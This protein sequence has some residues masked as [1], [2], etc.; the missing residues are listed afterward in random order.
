MFPVVNATVPV[1]EAK[2]SVSLATQHAFDIAEEDGHWVGE[3]SANSPA[4]RHYLVSQQQEDGSWSI[5]P[6]CPGD[7]LTSTEAYLA[8]GILGVSAKTPGMLRAKAFIRRCGGVAK[9]RDFTR[10][11][12]AQFEVFPW[13]AVPQLPAEFILL[14]SAFFLN[15]YKQ[16]S[17]RRASLGAHEA[18]IRYLAN[19]QETEVWFG[20]WGCNY[21]Y[22]TSNVFC[23]LQY[24]VDGNGQVLDMMASATGW[25]KQVQNPDG[26][27]GED[28]EFYDGYPWLGVGRRRLR[29]RPG[30][31]WQS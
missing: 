26:G 15:K 28:L 7:V 31:S 22:G 11:F 21:I 13:D 17:H 12:F 5:A 18:A 3:V 27:W 14:P 16:G 23:G 25:L 2:R 24:F 29:R 8:L 20:R 30:A 10:I 6:S 1:D 9:S 19:T 4:S